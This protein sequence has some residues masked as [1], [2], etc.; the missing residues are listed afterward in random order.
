MVF[1]RDQ[2]ERRQ[3]VRLFYLPAETPFVPFPHSFL[4][5]GMREIGDKQLWGPRDGMDDVAPGQ[6][7]DNALSWKNGWNMPPLFRNVTGHVCGTARQWLDGSVEGDEPLEWTEFG[8][9]T[10]CQ[11]VV[12]VGTEYR[13]PRFGEGG[14]SL[15]DSAIT[16][17]PDGPVESTKPLCLPYL[18]I[19]PQLP[20]SPP[21]E[22]HVWFYVDPD[23][24]LPGVMY[25]DES[26]ASLLTE[27]ALATA[28]AA[29]T[30]TDGLLDWA[31][32]NLPPIGAGTGTLVEAYLGSDQSFTISG[33][34]VVQIDTV[35]TDRLSEFDDS[36]FTWTP[37]SDGL[38]LITFYAEMGGP[39]ARQGTYVKGPGPTPVYFAL[40]T[41]NNPGGTILFR[42]EGG[43]DYQFWEE[44]GPD[45]DVITAGQDT[46]YLRIVRVL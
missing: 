23:T 46:T 25:P 44:H 26:T 10:C 24:G 40:G 9:S 28:L 35:T 19:L 33:P 30:P 2:N 38:Y 18:C 31:E 41:L 5:G 45:G 12:P 7:G 16:D 43:E 13:I 29:Y 20:A 21:E 36:T 14:L 34:E 37:V 17:P 27:D 4:L 15:T 1:W 11:G 22:G 8:F 42:A 6:V 3:R 39:E 32:A